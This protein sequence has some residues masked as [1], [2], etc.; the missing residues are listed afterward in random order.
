MYMYVTVCIL[1]VLCTC[2]MSCYCVKLII[3]MLLINTAWDLLRID[4]QG[5]TEFC[6]Y[7]LSKHPGYFISPLRL[8]GSTIESVF[9]QFKFGAGGKLDAANYRVARAT[10]LT[11][12]ASE[13][14]H[15]G[16]GYRDE[17]LSEH[18]VTLAACACVS[19]SVDATLKI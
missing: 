18:D 2:T 4:I 3:I 7:F 5:F 16:K 13:G 9:G 1:I 14:Y 19:I 10:F 6:N 12:Q 17:S 15:S 11:K 8:S